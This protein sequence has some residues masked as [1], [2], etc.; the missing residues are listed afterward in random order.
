MPEIA[1]VLAEQA[2]L[3][4]AL[5]METIPH[6]IDLRP[7]EFSREAH[8]QLWRLLRGL[9]KAGKPC[10]VLAVLAEGGDLETFG[11]GAYLSSLPEKAPAVEAAAYYASVVR[12]AATRR[13]TRLEILKLTEALDDGS[14]DLGETLAAAE[15]AF[16]AL[17]TTTARASS[18]RL[19]EAVNAEMQEIGERTAA[20]QRGCSVGWTTGYGSLDRMTGG[21]RPGRTWFIGG[22]PGKGKTAL[23][24]EMALRTARAGTKVGILS[25][26]MKAGQ[27]AGRTLACDG[28]VN[29]GLIRDGLDRRERWDPIVSAAE[30]LY[31]LPV[32]IDDSPMKA[33]EV[34]GRVTRIVRDRGCQVVFFDYLQLIRAARG[35]DY[36]LLMGDV[37]KGIAEVAK[38]EG[39]CPVALSQLSREVDRRQDQHPMQADFR[40]TGDIEDAAWVMLGLWRDPECDDM[41]IDVIKA[42]EGKCGRVKCRFFGDTQR[43]VEVDGRY[44]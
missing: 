34:V 11:G 43:I 36:R 35:E 39:V 26:E 3:G 27:I 21:F 44:E 32:W 22:R 18:V 9:A 19:G 28:D 12:T 38:T 15:K 30:R 20:R 10:G 33:A 1:P 13:A 6:D 5:I 24:L 29:H 41:D 7:E 8:V 4:C 40:E 14:T 17:S 37:A 2:L 16:R 42:R 31:E 25:M 23:A